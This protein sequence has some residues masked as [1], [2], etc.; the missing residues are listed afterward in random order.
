MKLEIS[1]RENYK[2]YANTW[3]QNNILL[4]KQFPLRKSEENFKFLE[5][6]ENRNI[7]SQ[8]L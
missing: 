6:N 3:T 7:T 1:S 4:N 2:H 5:A 8:N